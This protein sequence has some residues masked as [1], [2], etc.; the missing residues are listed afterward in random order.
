VTSPTP[1]EKLH[2]VHVVV[3]LQVGGLERVVLSLVQEGLRLSQQVSVVCLET[4][5]PVARQIEESGA[6]VLRM[7]KRRGL[8]PGIIPQIKRTLVNI[9][10][11]IVHTHQIGA[12]L[13]AGPAARLARVPVIVHTEHGKHFDRR[14]TRWMG[15]LAGLTAQRYFC[16]SADIAAGV[17]SHRVAP[18]RK[19]VVVAN[20]ID[21]AHFAKP[22]DVA[23][24][25]QQ[26]GIPASAAVIGTV[27]NL[28][29]VKRQD[30]LIRGFAKL[31][32]FRGSRPHLLLVGDGELRSELS[33]LAESLGVADR[34]H[35]AGAQA[36]PERFLHVMDVF[37][38]T[39]RSE[40]MPLSV[41]EAQAAGLPVVA[42]RVG[43]LPEIV[44]D[45][46]TGLL[47]EPGDE[48][49]LAS[50]FEQL[51]SEP[52]RMTEMGRAGQAAVRAKYDVSVMAGTYARHYRELLER[53]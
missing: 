30:V 4:D 29:E 51:L 52:T 35:F 11:T 25:R 6:R 47:F 34:V 33:R 26:M 16:V 23:G 1:S 5:G 46:R 32:E 38:L 18:A 20:G 2:V 41:L 22:G 7:G 42:S 50:C 9:G 40:G 37:A 19:V 15:R 17:V 8:T 45:S 39:S 48:A 53:H 27:A 12:L 13:Y 36:N 14:R 44:E 28:R 10:A 31:G 43:G 49:A 21:T 3:G 24:L